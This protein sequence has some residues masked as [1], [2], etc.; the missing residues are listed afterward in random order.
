[1]LGTMV[2]KDLTVP[3]I[4][5]K[6]EKMLGLFVTCQKFSFFREIDIAKKACQE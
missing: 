5:V 4:N 3:F 6:C 2:L 1:M